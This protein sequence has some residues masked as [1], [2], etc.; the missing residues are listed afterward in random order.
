MLI[1]HTL[2]PS[3]VINW[4]IYIEKARKKKIYRM[5]MHANQHN[6]DYVN[7]HAN[8]CKEFAKG[9][10]KECEK[11]ILE[12]QTARLKNAFQVVTG[13]KIQRFNRVQ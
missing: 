4:K 6:P 7:H 3:T 8:E 10:S 9:S 2:Q 13:P 1:K 5:K 11:R 12:E